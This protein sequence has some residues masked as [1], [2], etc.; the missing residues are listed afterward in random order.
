M[1]PRKDVNK[2]IYSVA[3]YKPDRYRIRRHINSSVDSF[4]DGL[5]IRRWA[6]AYWNSSIILNLI[7]QLRRSVMY[8][9][10]YLCERYH[11]LYHP[12]GEESTHGLRPLS[13]Q[14]LALC[15]EPPCHLHFCSTA[16]DAF[17]WTCLVNNDHFKDDIKIWKCFLHTDSHKRSA[18]CT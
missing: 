13:T 6:R 18:I 11:W 2:I 1:Q 10:T 4:R 14:K 17:I 3:L 5:Y 8:S 12:S 9:H 16:Y 7:G 15:T